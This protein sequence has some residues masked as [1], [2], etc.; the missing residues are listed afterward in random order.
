M[1][2]DDDLHG[3]RLRGQDLEIAVTCDMP[4]RGK[5][6]LVIFA[7]D[8]VYES[9]ARLWPSARTGSY[10]TFTLARRHVKWSVAS[11]MRRG[12]VPLFASTRQLTGAKA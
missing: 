6:I 9:C 8:L 10:S 2:E 1:N 3:S 7:G 4:L 12:D 11:D 5:R